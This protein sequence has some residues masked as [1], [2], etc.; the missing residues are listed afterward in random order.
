MMNYTFNICFP[1]KTFLFCLKKLKY[2]FLYLV[3]YGLL[4]CD[5]G[6]YIERN[7]AIRIISEWESGHVPDAVAH[8]LFNEVR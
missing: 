1:D 2:I 4:A 5:N 6:A 8:N 3:I 7:D